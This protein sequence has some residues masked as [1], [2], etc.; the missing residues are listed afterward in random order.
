MKL[1]K[2]DVGLVEQKLIEQANNKIA[3][4]ISSYE[5]KELPSKLKKRWMKI[6]EQRNMA[7]RKS[8]TVTKKKDL[9]ANT[10]KL[11]ELTFKMMQVK[12]ERESEG[13][14]TSAVE[15]PMQSPKGL[16]TYGKTPVVANGVFTPPPADP[17]Q[18][19]I[20]SGIQS[21]LK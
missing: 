11:D 16:E 17:A 19:K 20:T 18:N 7:F 1:L 4:F 21:F 10:E 14:M 8:V 13:E 12:K 15:A 6:L 2:D 3:K 9:Q 5:D